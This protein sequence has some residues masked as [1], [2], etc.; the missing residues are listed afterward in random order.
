M[1]KQ[2]TATWVLVA[3][4]AT[5][6]GCLVAAAGAGA[7][8]GIYYSERGA[9][10]LVP[11]SIEQATVA[12]RRVF[13]QFKIAETKVTAESSE[14]EERGEIAGTS[15][16]RNEDITV[17]LTAEGSGSTRVQVVARKTAVTWD[18]DYARKI[19]QEIV[20]NAR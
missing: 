3:A 1:R 8:G 20:A 17:T 12:T 18:R 15:S 11:V 9:E 2:L 19:L 7:G 10:G 13:G 5:L 14:G 16:S 6:A 4:T